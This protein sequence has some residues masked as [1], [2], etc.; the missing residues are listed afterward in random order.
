MHGA[1]RI[2]R[3][4]LNRKRLSAG[5]RRQQENH[6]LEGLRSHA[7]LKEAPLSWIVKSIVNLHISNHDVDRAKLQ[8]T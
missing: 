5:E 7:A 8:Q 4:G 3:L 1:S 2:T 6:S